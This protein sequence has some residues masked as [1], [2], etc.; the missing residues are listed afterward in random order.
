MSLTLVAATKRDTGNPARFASNPAVR[1]PKFPLGVD[2]PTRLDRPA[3]PPGRP[4]PPRPICRTRLPHRTCLS[5]L[6]CLTCLTHRVEVINRLRQE[7]PDV[8]RIGRREAHAAAELG[9]GERFA[10]QPV[11]VA[12]AA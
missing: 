4:G 10:G 9:I 2:N 8:H 6:T 12:E 7:T 1:F 11:A 5:G 3:R